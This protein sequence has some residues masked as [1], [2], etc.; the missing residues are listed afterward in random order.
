LLTL[1]AIALTPP[2]LEAITFASHPGIRYVLARDVAKLKGWPMVYDRVTGLAE[3]N[4]KPIPVDQPRLFNGD[5]LLNGQTYSPGVEPGAKRV[6]IDLASQTLA[7]YQG[8]IG[9]MRVKIN[10]GDPASETPA[11]NYVAGAKKA[12][13]VSSIYGSKMPYSIHLRGNYYLHGS[14]QTLRGPGSHGCIR[15]PMYNGAA[16]YL[17]DWIDRGTPVRVQGRRP[18]PNTKSVTAPSRDR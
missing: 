7:A 4:G 14:G 10:S 11:G 5:I 15:L 6:T 3:L 12:D 2:K 17:Y 18:P 8:K 13:K 16:K 9:V 1:L